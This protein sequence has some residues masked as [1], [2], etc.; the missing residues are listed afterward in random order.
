MIFV[1][2]GCY[3]QARNWAAANE[4]APHEWRFVRSVDTL[5][6]ARD[7]SIVYTGTFYDREDLEAIRQVA[8]AAGLR[9]WTLDSK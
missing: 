1:V 6:G 5:R 8:L 2:A 4:V 9:R 7:D 3:Q